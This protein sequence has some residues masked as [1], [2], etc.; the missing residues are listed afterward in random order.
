MFETKESFLAD[1]AEKGH[2]N[3]SKSEILRAIAEFGN[4]QEFEEWR[5]STV[6]E[7]NISIEKFK[8]ED[9]FK[10][11]VKCDYEFSCVC[12]TIERAMEMAGMYQQ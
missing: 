8:N 10:V 9:W 5:I 3:T 11:T 12:P 4:W 7:F 1:L 6:T 2:L